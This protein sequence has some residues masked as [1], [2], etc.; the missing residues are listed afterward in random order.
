MFKVTLNGRDF[1]KSGENLYNT[2]DKVVLEIPSMTD[3]NQYVSSADVML[4]REDSNS[5]RMVYSFIMPDHDVDVCMT[6][7]GSMIN[8]NYRPVQAEAPFVVCRSCGSKCPLS[9]KFC[10]ECGQ[11]LKSI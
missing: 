8:P 1:P 10:T 7:S 5:Y 6:V 3:V 4:K 11:K 9:Y 2:G